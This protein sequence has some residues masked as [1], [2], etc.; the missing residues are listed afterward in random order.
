M[1]TVESED[2]V[3]CGCVLYGFIINPFVLILFVAHSLTCVHLWGV[4]NRCF[5]LNGIIYSQWPLNGFWAKNQP[6]FGTPGLCSGKIRL[7]PLDWRQR[8]RRLEHREEKVK[9]RARWQTMGEL[10]W[11]SLMTESDCVSRAAGPVNTRI[12]VL[13]GR[14][15][16][17]EED[18]D[19]LWRMEGGFTRRSKSHRCAY[20]MRR[21]EIRWSHS[22]KEKKGAWM[23]PKKEVN[24]QLWLWD[25]KTDS[26]WETSH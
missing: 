6:H 2:P 14:G 23:G 10:K 4:D 5:W 24:D 8:T 22:L 13:W 18:L 17:N 3:I 19:F 25:L 16:R 9:G 15:G 20:Q 26:D 12:T 1:R 11:L 7:T 21:R